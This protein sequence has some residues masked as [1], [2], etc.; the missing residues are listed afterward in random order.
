MWSKLEVLE[1]TKED[2]DEFEMDEI[3]A[4]ESQSTDLTAGFQPDGLLDM[5]AR[6]FVD[7]S[8]ICL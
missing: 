1:T 3:A 5:I 8:L 2:S 7:K 6:S 4:S